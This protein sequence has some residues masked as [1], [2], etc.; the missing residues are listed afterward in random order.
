MKTSDKILN[1]I[2]NN[3]QFTRA[4]K[5]TFWTA[6]GLI[7]LAFLFAYQINRKK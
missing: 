5:N 2:Y 4:A 3:Y 1:Y 7:G 6:G